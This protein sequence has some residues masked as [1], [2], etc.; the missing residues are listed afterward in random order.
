MIRL[1]SLS[2]LLLLTPFSCSP[3]PPATTS[4]SKT[5]SSSRSPRVSLERPL[6]PDEL[7]FPPLED[8]HHRAR[9]QLELR[10]RSAPAIE[11]T[12]P[13]SEQF[14]VQGQTLE[15]SFSQAAVGAK[16]GAPA[17]GVLELTPPVAGQTRWRDAQTL[18]F[19][20]EHPF[21]PSVSYQVLLKEIKGTLGTAAL[22]W[23]GTFTAQGPQIAGKE[24]GYLPQRGDTRAVALSV[25]DDA[26]VSQRPR[27]MV[28]YDQ[29]V[30]LAF[31]RQHV[32]LTHADG[33]KLPLRHQVLGYGNFNGTAAPAGHRVSV[34]VLQE[35]PHGFGLTLSASDENPST[36]RTG[37][38]A[39]ISVA[40]PFSY[41]D[42]LCN[43]GSTSC[44]RRGGTVLLD[45]RRLSLLFNNAVEEDAAALK[46]KVLVSPAV[47]NLSIYSYDG[48]RGGELAL[49]GDFRPGTNYRISANGL[50]D[51][52]GNLLLEPLRLS[53][54]QR[55]ERASLSMPG[56][57]LWLD[58]SAARAFEFDARNVDRA[59]LWIW[60][61]DPADTHDFATALNTPSEITRDAPFSVLPI[62]VRPKLDEVVTTS[63]DLSRVLSA[64]QSYVIQLRHDQTAFD[65]IPPEYPE[66]S[67]AS[68]PPTAFV[69]LAGKGALLVHVHR[70]P[71]SV[72]VHVADAGTGAPVSKAQ[73]RLGLSDQTP[74][75][76]T[77]ADGVA[78]V[79]SSNGEDAADAIV[80][81]RAGAKRV[82]LPAQE[83]Q[84]SAAH[85]FPDL[86]RVPGDPTGSPVLVHTDR[87][88]YRPGET[89]HFK[90]TAFTRGTSAPGLKPLAKQPLT[91]LLKGPDGRE[92]VEKKPTTNGFGSVELDFLVPDGAKLGSYNLSVK[93]K[94]GE[95]ATRSVRVAAF[96][97][98]KFVIDI[99][100]PDRVSASEFSARI[101]GRYLF[102]APLAGEN[103]SW[104]LSAK[105]AVVNGGSLA[106]AGLRFDEEQSYWDAEA[107][108]GVLWTQT[109][110]GALD[111][112]GDRE[113]PVA[114]PG[115]RPDKPVLVTLQAEVSDASNRAAA[116]RREVVVHPSQ[117]YA[118]LRLARS[119][120]G[121]KEPIAVALG[122][123]D[124]SGAPLVGVPVRAEL[125]RV[126]WVEVTERTKDGSLN[127]TWREKRERVASC[128]GTSATSAV[129]C[130]LSPLTGGYYRVAAYVDGRA[131]G[132]Q[133]LWV[134]GASEGGT[135]PS[136]RAENRLNLV[137]DKA[138]Y[139]P[140]ETAH[141]LVENP[142]PAATALV[143]L[144]SDRLVSH[145]VVSVNQ[146][147]STLDIPLEGELAPFAHATVTLLPLSKA[148][149]L[150][151]PLVGALRLPVA[152]RDARLQVTVASDKAAYRPR[153]T[154]TLTV[155]V[156]RQGVR[157]GDVEVALAV[158][159]EGVLRL[160]GFHAP[161][162]LERLWTGFPL[163]F[164]YS[165]T[166]SGFAE[167]MQRSH[168][169]GDGGSEQGAEPFLTRSNFVTTALWKPG[170][171][172]NQEGRVQV[173][174]KLPDNLTEFRMLAVALDKQGRAGSRESSFRVTEPVLVQPAMPRFAL[175]GDRFEAAAMLHNTTAAPFTGSLEVLGKTERIALPA[176]SRVRVGKMM[177]ATTAGSRALEFTL[178]DSS[179]RAVDSVR[180]TLD[181]GVPGALQHP[182]LI[183]S[184]AG[185]Q[186]I[187]LA[188][189]ETAA[190]APGDMLE[191]TVG[192]NLHPELGEQL[193]FLL[194]YPHGCVEQTT[195]STLPLL[196]ARQI[197]PLLGLTAHNQAFF[198]TRIEHGLKRLDTMRTAEG[199]LAYW[200][201][202]QEPSVFGTAY[203]MRAVVASRK[204]G[205]RLPPGLDQG[206]LDY[207]RKQLFD[208]R[209]VPEV[210]S[211]IALSLAES[212]RLSPTDTDALVDAA[213]EMGVFGK[214][215]LA[216]ALGELKGQ[217]DRVTR[218][219][220]DIERVL[221]EGGD[222]GPKNREDL[223]SFDSDTRALAQASLAL[224]HLKPASPEL[225]ELVN[226]LL[227][228]DEGYTT[229][230]TAY[231]LLALAE[232]VKAGA[233][234][235][236]PVVTLDG[237]P[238][239]PTGKFAGGGRSYAVPLSELK[240]RER[241]LVLSGDPKR[242][243]AFAVSANYT[244]P[245]QNSNAVAEANAVSGDHGPDLYRVFTTPEGEPVD[246][247]R[248]RAGQV[249]R[250]AL[251]AL[252]PASQRQT[253]FRYLA[254]TDALPAGFEAVDTSL[255]TVARVADA[256]SAHPFDEWLRSSSRP[257]HLELDTAKVKIYFD[258]PEG[259]AAA[260]SYLVRA[261]TPGSFVLP[262]ASAELMY[263][264]YSTSFSDAG[265]VTIQ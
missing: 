92:L 80:E 176:K 178:R 231:Q 27:L 243:V 25:G 136:P 130:S 125:E 198:D 213:K 82:V 132:A 242:H 171:V 203:A 138:A 37:L 32:N 221:R 124:T 237:A 254:I 134:M 18:E 61:V 115:G 169:A 216:L 50:R 43:Y 193:E 30:T 104:S 146:R 225:P 89:L 183:G 228:I 245:Y 38:E 29:P 223:H 226:S 159:D 189:P 222:L 179:G 160:T 211:A 39:S 126:R 88:I 16:P 230:A 265:R 170:L 218:L 97:P 94:A 180:H 28:L 77:A 110:S 137:P 7:A 197:L 63:V 79:N 6:S 83:E 85:L 229:Q 200:P 24:L 48:Y 90:V 190:S 116:A 175:Q 244:L 201:G 98:P 191:L 71:G 65:A 127:S 239:E 235:T 19:V 40:P 220:N 69:S 143:T 10:S 204:L 259:T 210:R 26:R 70:A 103:V 240:G 262:R 57:T 15:F 44:A 236:P 249:L 14:W 257:D 182:R 49:S 114:L 105:P 11:V 233:D 52:H 158:V 145:R 74:W 35:V 113:L 217:S 147:L 73:V 33:T 263:E 161:D 51:R 60:H 96:D 174:F 131:G 45:D 188:V 100:A 95:L 34:E 219:V 139:Q 64:D 264:P 84:K 53:V 72:L 173:S 209:V 21:D 250:V 234:G 129:P 119:W 128:S 62:D 108:T 181:V 13:Y 195:S 167:W 184:F 172:T 58:S 56:G 256:G 76:T 187:V 224:F 111:A 2:L 165:D 153:D 99:D 208:A 164:G 214:S 87:D 4:G 196:A 260:V 177:T 1:P 91:L 109:G 150:R 75:A 148:A 54:V 246:L 86:A 121:E 5:D 31:A 185:K 78:R 93:G 251:L 192:E 102:G 122:V 152:L 186:N 42:A 238:L 101:S 135:D 41:T 81:V 194:G 17:G 8:P 252:Q 212:D 199:G 117:R 107:D 255:E 112:A 36:D 205:I 155:D 3:A 253:K 207:L 258:A 215:N 248:V 156:T 141:V 232:H 59:Q 9:A 154:A 149:R 202:N 46:R 68:T 140:G 261:T 247:S 12:S 47:K 206:M 123:V 20:A 118:G 162:P 120:Y 106:Q 241:R 157:Q 163:T 166:R 142:W 22:S 144:E 66:G 133:R 168:V 67:A 227:Q 55:P 151:A 23:R